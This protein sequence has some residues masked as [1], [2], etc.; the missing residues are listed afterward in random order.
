VRH[1][2]VLN[3]AAHGGRTGALQA[4]L[5]A[6][7][8]AKGL[9]ATFEATRAP[10]ESTGRLARLEPGAF[11]VVVAAGGDGTLFEV[12]NGLMALPADQR[13]AL[14]IL[15]LGTGNAFAR[16]LGLAP[17]DWRGALEALAS[18][19]RCRVDV[20][21][22]NSDGDTFWFINMLGL[23]FVEDAARQAKKLK[24]LGRSAYTLGALVRLLAMPSYQLT[25]TLDGKPLSGERSKGEASR[26]SLFFLE[27]ANSRFT[28][29][30]F[31]MAPNAQIDDGLFDVV[32]VRSL[33]LLR[34]F[35]LFPTIYDGRHLAEPEVEVHR[36]RT[37]E[38]SAKEPIGGLIVDGEFHGAPPL[39]I[40]C[41]PRAIEVVG[42]AKVV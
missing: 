11:D 30:R 34:A 31:L 24:W 9:S 35:R 40:Q 15:P 39:V 38:I 28:G 14:G 5:A 42:S 12:V 26:E 17:G 3:P 7:F 41:L 29:T 36:A 16:D 27:V 21:E 1:L 18:G 37:V 4:E 32:I 2:V 22:V 6:A 33:S 25:V 10:G 19:Q 20:G 13:P 8:A 23:G